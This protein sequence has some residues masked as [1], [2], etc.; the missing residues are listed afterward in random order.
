MEENTARMAALLQSSSKNAN[1]PIED[2]QDLAR[3][4][5]YGFSQKGTQTK[6]KEAKGIQDEET[7]DPEYQPDDAEKAAA[8]QDLAAD[9]EERRTNT[10]QKVIYIHFN[11]QLH[12]TML[13]TH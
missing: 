9:E 10:L 12:N 4:F 8:E 6:G 13:A 2:F 3:S 5:V 1:A 11:F 7:F